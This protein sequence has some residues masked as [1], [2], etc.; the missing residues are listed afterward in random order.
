MINLALLY[1]KSPPKWTRT[2]PV[3]FR[4]VHTTFW[5]L[6]CVLIAVSLLVLA[7]AQAAMV[8]SAHYM[9]LQ[10][11]GAYDVEVLVFSRGT[12]AAT[13]PA[14]QVQWVDVSDT[15]RLQEKPD[16][17]PEW[18]WATAEHTPSADNSHWTMPVE[19]QKPQV[20]VD[21]ARGDLFLNK[22]AAKL[23]QQPGWRVLLHRK[24]RLQP[25]DFQQPVYLNLSTTTPPVSQAPGKGEAMSGGS[26]TTMNEETQPL[27]AQMETAPGLL[28]KLAFSKGRYLHIDARLQKVSTSPNGTLGV[29]TLQEKRRV[30]SKVLQYFDHPDFGVLVLIT[31]LQAPQRPG[32]GVEPA[33]EGENNAA[34]QASAKQSPDTTAENSTVNPQNQGDPPP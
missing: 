30:H 28:G 34:K 27:E 9:P 24:W 19:E 7:S 2:N 29:S 18:K 21:Y 12:Q 32:S 11:H 13:R 25:S 31:P 5:P 15:I 16:N 17:W 33:K 20:L 8:Q 1:W 10:K 14:D 22:T 6:R 26:S 3:A 23:N 4:V